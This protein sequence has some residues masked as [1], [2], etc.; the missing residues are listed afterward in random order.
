MKKDV[1]DF[2]AK[3]AI[4]QKIKYIPKPPMTLLQPIAPPKNVSGDLSM[5]FVVN[6]PAFLNN[7]VVVRFLPVV[8]PDDNLHIVA[9]L[10]TIYMSSL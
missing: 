2:V 9:F 8:I 1:F 10:T 7:S 6:L 4:C 3:C 5:D